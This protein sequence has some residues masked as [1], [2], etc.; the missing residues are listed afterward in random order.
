LRLTTRNTET[1]GTAAS[2]GSFLVL[3]PQRTWRNGSGCSRMNWS[4]AGSTHHRGRRRTGPPGHRGRRR[5]D[6]PG[7]GPPRPARRTG[8]KHPLL[9][10]LADK[11][12]RRNL[13]VH[14]G[15]VRRRPSP[16]PS[17]CPPAPGSTPASTQAR[18]IRPRMP[19]SAKALAAQ[20]R[21]LLV[22]SSR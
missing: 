7:A 10:L 20:I 5:G 14:P 17:S 3:G 22:V 19:F 6:R 2:K 4:C 15:V 16:A 9:Q 1:A 11:R 21:S 13:G 12:I 18:R 8:M